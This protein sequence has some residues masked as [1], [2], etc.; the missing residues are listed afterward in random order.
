MR[1]DRA[2]TLGGGQPSDPDPRDRNG[3]STPRHARVSD[4]TAIAAVHVRAWAETYGGLL[5]A[6]AI[7]A[8]TF[9]SRVGFWTERLRAPPSDSAV[10]V[11]EHDDDGI[12]GFASVEPAWSVEAFADGELSTLYVASRHQGRGLGRALVHA[13]RVHAA[14][15]GWRRLGLWVLAE[16]LRAFS[17]YRHTGATPVT[18]RCEVEDDLEL[19]ELGLVYE[20]TGR[21]DL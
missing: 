5:P 4:A 6:A 2:S 18:E 20:S 16:N 3:G 11:V 8:R 15:T 13:A 21:P 9:E 12:V 10:F 19:R 7:V 17:F 14:T 1:G